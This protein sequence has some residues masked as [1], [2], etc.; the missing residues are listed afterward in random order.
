VLTNGLGIVK[1]SLHQRNNSTVTEM[2]RC[3]E[4]L[5]F[6]CLIGV[7]ALDIW[8]LKFRIFEKDL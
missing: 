1:L 4:V 6:Y 2:I 8:K 7:M 5:I 3:Y